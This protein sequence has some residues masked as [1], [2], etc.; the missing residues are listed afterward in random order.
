[1]ITLRK[2]E[3]ALVRL[4]ITNNHFEV[5]NNTMLTMLLF[6]LSTISNEGTFSENTTTHKSWEFT[7]CDCGTADNHDVVIN[8][9]AT[10]LIRLGIAPIDIEI[11][12]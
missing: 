9:V 1:M 6:V 7:L 4:T 10:S 12:D 11:I 5:L 8:L 3:P 2:V